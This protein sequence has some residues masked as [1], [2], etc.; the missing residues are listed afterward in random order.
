MSL[1]IKRFEKTSGIAMLGLLFVFAS[2]IN[3]QNN[4]NLEDIRTRG[5]SY[6][7]VGNWES[8]KVEFENAIAIAP[9]DTLSIYGNS[10]ALFNLRNYSD[11]KSNLETGIEILSKTQENKQFLADFLVLSSVISAIENKNALAITN[12]EKAVRLVPNHFDAN[13]SLGRAY[14]GNG[15]IDKSIASF[16][17]AAVIQ[18][19]NSRA[20]FFLATALERAGSNIEALAEYRKVLEIDPNNPDGNLGLGVLLIKT[21]GNKSAEGL[22]AL[23]KSVEINANLYEGQI[24]LGK[25]LIRLNQTK[26]AIEHLQKAAELAPDNPEPH[27]QLAIAY[28]KLGRKA[29]AEAETERVKTIHENRRGVAGQKP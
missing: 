21:D 3:A 26:E 19:Q 14:F 22:K 6:L 15:D 20:R 24:T 9:K 7:K 8:A 16:R 2:I 11:A 23:K 29:D 17:Q 13:F 4:Q 1:N 27:Y 12:L 10:L 18:P 28:R 25:T 5:F